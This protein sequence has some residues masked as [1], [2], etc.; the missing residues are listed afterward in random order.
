MS[1]QVALLCG[2]AVRRIL[3]GATWKRSLLEWVCVPHELISRGSRHILRSKCGVRNGRACNEALRNR[4][5][6]GI[7]ISPEA[8]AAWRAP[9]HPTGGGQ[10]IHSDLAGH[11]SCHGRRTSF[12]TGWPPPHH[13]QDHSQMSQPHGP[14]WTPGLRPCPM[15]GPTVW[16]AFAPNLIRAA[17]HLAA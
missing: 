15:I 5:S 3:P 16:G 14:T 10:T 4:A 9:R 8:L 7:W 2:S 12:Q 6:L 17:K 1:Y 11:G 13:S